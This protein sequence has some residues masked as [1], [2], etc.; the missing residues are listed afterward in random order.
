[1]ANHTFNVI[2]IKDLGGST[3]E[4][5]RAVMLNSK[6]MIDFERIHPCPECL[7]DFTPGIMVLDFVGEHIADQVFD[8]I[9]YFTNFSTNRNYQFLTEANKRKIRFQRFLVYGDLWKDGVFPVS[10]Y[11]SEKIVKAKLNRLG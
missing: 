1:M 5:V 4:A 8:N 7:E 9:V 2:E 6:N 11:S 3:M 10:L